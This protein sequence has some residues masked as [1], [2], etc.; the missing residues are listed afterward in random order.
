MPLRNSEEKASESIL[1]PLGFAIGEL[2]ADWEGILE[3]YICCHLIYSM[4]RIGYSSTVEIVS[5]I[6]AQSL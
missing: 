6:K 4:A 1:I 2:V 5:F 3:V